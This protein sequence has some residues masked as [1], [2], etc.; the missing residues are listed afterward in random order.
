[1]QKASVP[2]I[3]DILSPSKPGTRRILVGEYKKLLYNRCIFFEEQYAKRDEEPFIVHDV[4]ARVVPSSTFWFIG[5]VG[6]SPNITTNEA[7]KSLEILLI[8][9]AKT[10]RKIELG[11]SEAINGQF[12]IWIAP[13]NAEMQ[14]AQ[15]KLKLTN[16]LQFNT[17]TT[18]YVNFHQLGYQPEVYQND[19]PGFRI[20]RNDQG[21][22]IEAEYDINI[23][24][25]LPEDDQRI[26][27]TDAIN[28]M[29]VE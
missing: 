17:N 15:N 26:D 28:K 14:C 4:Y 7:F 23:R 5:K 13:G 12:Q 1:V 29:S 11:G 27:I 22:A 8:E 6:H 9:Y 3:S 16:A 25:R 18:N 20:K 21:E 10:L 19:E 2:R 24:S